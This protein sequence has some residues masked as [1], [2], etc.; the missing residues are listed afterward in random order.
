MRSCRGALKVFDGLFHKDM[1]EPEKEILG[2]GETHIQ[3]RA[4]VLGTLTEAARQPT[5]ERLLTDPEFSDIL[6]VVENDLLEEYLDNE[7][8]PAERESLEGSYLT[9]PQ[10]KNRLRLIRTVREYSAAESKPAAIAK[11]PVT[12]DKK[13]GGS[14]FSRFISTPWPAVAMITAVIAVSLLTWFLFFRPSETDRINAS[15]NRAFKLERPFK[16]RV[17]G[18]NYAPVGTTR[19]GSESRIDRRALDQAESLAREA[20]LAKETAESL[21]NEGRVLLL[22]KDFARAIESLERASKLAPQS[23]EVMNELGVAQLEQSA[24]EDPLIDDIKLRLRAVALANFKKALALDPDLT[25]AYFNAAICVQALGVVDQAIEAWREYLKRDASSAWATEAKKN[26]ELIESRKT[27]SKTA[28]EIFT[29]FMTA[30]RA[31]DDETA[32]RTVSRNREMITGKL[33]PQQMIFRFLNSQGDAR[34]QYLAALN[35]VGRLESDRSHDPYYR[36]IARFYG[37]ATA[38][39]IADSRTAYELVKQGYA[40]CQ[41]ADY[42]VAFDD[43][44]RARELF[45]QTGNGWEANTCEYWLAYCEFQLDRISSSNERLNRVTEYCQRLGYKWLYAQATHWL[46]INTSASS[47]V[48]KALNFLDLSLRASADVSDFYNVQKNYI[49]LAAVQSTVRQFDQALRNL[50]RVLPVLSAPEFSLR[51]KWKGLD[52]IA[53]SFFAM[54]LF[55]AAAC[56]EKE[57]LDLNVNQI[58]DPS[59]QRVGLASLSR[60]FNSQ[61]LYAE[62]VAYA[63][64][65]R[66]A[67]EQIPNE[68]NRQKGIG[69]AFLQSAAAEFERGDRQA[70]LT[71]YE[72]A[73]SI[74]STMEFKPYQYQAEKGQLLCYLANGDDAAIQEVMPKVLSLFEANRD[75][76]LEEQNRDT[77]FDEEQNVYDLATEYTFKQGNDQLAFDYAERS[78]SRSLLDWQSN[79]GKVVFSHGRPQIVFANDGIPSPLTS[80]EIRPKIPAQTQLL[81]YAILPTRVLI[82]VITN[83]ISKSFS[84]DIPQGDLVDRVVAFLASIKKKDS[85][86][87]IELSRLLCHVLIGPVEASLD[88]SKSIVIIPDKIL[89]HLPFAALISEQS[90]KYL[91]ESYRFSYAPSANVFLL[92]NANAARRTATEPGQEKLLSIGNPTFDR[93]EFPDL[94]SLPSAEEEARSIAT[95]YPNATLL[96]GPDATKR[97]IQQNIVTADVVQF[98]GHY[99]ANEQSY[100]RSSFAVAGNDQDSRLS[101]YELLEA[102]LDRPQLLILSACQTGI[103]GYYRG[104]G[105]IG[106]GRTFLAL[107][108]PLV[109]ATQW[110]VDSEAT[111]ELI[112]NFHRLRKQDGLPTITALQRAQQAMLN[113]PNSF[114]REPYYWAGFF[115]L[116]G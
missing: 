96:I 32:Y 33:V 57:A 68:R 28:D 103:E 36:D 29:E 71:D 5:E 76:I 95:F 48:S 12:D 107:G 110:N 77:F 22:K 25:A 16:S 65:S 53:Q 115:A 113:G 26:L 11:P 97:R 50:A 94:P 37:Q 64:Q 47:E 2:D 70:A 1:E 23:A 61:K 73:V 116:G 19:G 9:T 85:A 114:L 3:V 79:R 31:G 75:L 15:L 51:L 43:F 7:L 84:Y 106:A 99:V 98:S 21:R 59:F 30:Y 17:S 34:R 10:G 46:S 38:T 20:A 112:K 62:A 111:G 69:Y 78:R 55:D 18:L 24:P 92:S 52:Q 90:G 88:A 66:D 91:V 42:G 56:F 81:Y 58:K 14:F 13:R 93:R 100:L 63:Q 101:N 39:Q 83:G 8:T 40:L 108:V 45:T 72:Q 80:A 67:A 27:L 35:Y 54:D 109:V 41:I 102:T 6:L 87:Q 104:E 60:I 105:M 82:W 4:Y 86:T 44:D 74:Y 89:C 49:Y